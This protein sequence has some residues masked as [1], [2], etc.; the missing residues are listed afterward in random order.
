[1]AASTL[2]PIT[3]AL[4]VGAIRDWIAE[5]GN[6]ALHYFG[7]AKTEWKDAYNPVTVADREIERMLTAQLRRAYPDHGILGE[8]YGADQLDRD[9]LWSIDPI[10]G[11]R[12]YIDGLPSWCVTI[13]LLHHRVPV[14]GVVYIPLYDD[15]TYTDG[16]DVICNGEVITDRLRPRWDMDSFLMWRSDGNLRYDLHFPRALSMSS[17]ASHLAYTAR[18]A[19]VATLSHDFYVWDVAAGVAFL[20]KQG[21][22]VRKLDG[23]P[24]DFAA[25]DLL[26]P[27][28]GMYVAGHPD[29]VERLIPLVRPRAEPITPPKW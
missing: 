29:V 25:G 16:D 20:L 24:L 27:V 9:Y 3:P 6:I 2:T 22:V 13:A 10:D 4:E 5:A 18:G 17:S 21:G 7:H 1:M 28:M 23:Q 14:F 8:E 11:T 15:W 19:A 26:K 12:A